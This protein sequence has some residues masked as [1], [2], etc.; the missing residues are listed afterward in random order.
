M[1]RWSLSR[2][3]AGASLPA[4]MV[5]VAEDDEALWSCGDR[6]R[7]GGHDLTETSSALLTYWRRSV[8]ANLTDADPLTLVP[9]RLCWLMYSSCLAGWHSVTGRS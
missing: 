3:G 6:D 5:P 1:T 4:V 8:A 2:T 7:E 9:K